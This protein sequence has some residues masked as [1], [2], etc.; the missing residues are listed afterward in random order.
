MK[1]ITPEFDQ[2]KIDAGKAAEAFLRDDTFLA[3]MNSAKERITN[4]WIRADTRKKREELHGAIVGLNAVVAE[5]MA[6][7]GGGK[8]A[9][10]LKDADEALS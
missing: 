1:R 9:Q 8:Q 6:A 7:A 4:S 10:R 5:L 3:A 2:R